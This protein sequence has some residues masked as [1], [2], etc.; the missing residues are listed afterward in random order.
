MMRLLLAGFP[1]TSISW[2]SAAYQR[3][4]KLP[5]RH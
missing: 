3:V 4:T 1:V 5:L 2:P